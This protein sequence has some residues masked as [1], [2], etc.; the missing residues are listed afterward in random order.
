MVGYENLE[1][2][3]AKQATKGKAFAKNSKVK[4]KQQQENQCKRESL[5]SEAGPSVL[6]K[7]ITGTSDWMNVV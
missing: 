1:E 7:K 6:K 2:V 5:A 4:Q 3:R